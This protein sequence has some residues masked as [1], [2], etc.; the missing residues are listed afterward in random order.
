MIGSGEGTF[1]PAAPLQHT[2]RLHCQASASAV[3][4][5]GGLGLYAFDH[6]PRS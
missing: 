6:S 5:P 3:V 4:D 2:L 1:A